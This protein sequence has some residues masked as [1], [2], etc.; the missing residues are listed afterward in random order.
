[1]QWLNAVGH[2]VRNGWRLLRKSPVLSGTTIATL[3]L[4]IGLDAGVFTLLDGLM[5]RAR[6]T[7]DPATFVQISVEDTGRSGAPVVG[8]P[9]TSLQDYRA[10]RDG[11][12]SVRDIAAWTPVT[13]SL[14]GNQGGDEAAPYKIVP[15][16]VTCNFFDV[17]DR[18]RPAGRSRVRSPGLRNAGPRAGRRDG[19]RVVAYPLQQ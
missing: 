3:A 2:D 5:F 6:V 1:M 8:L 9:F 16:L 12:R 10:Y 19:G 18:T 13:A 17:Y 11:V 14:G 4:G 7:D 15:L